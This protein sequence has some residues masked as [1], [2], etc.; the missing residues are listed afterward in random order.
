MTELILSVIQQVLSIHYVPGKALRIQRWNLE[1]IK[2]LTSKRATASHDR[3]KPKPYGSIWKKQRTLY[4][5]EIFSEE[6][7]LN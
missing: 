4:N 3:G 5:R 7:N 1:F 2:K 6:V